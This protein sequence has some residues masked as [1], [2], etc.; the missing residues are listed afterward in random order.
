[1]APKTKSKS[2]AA[3]AAEGK[4]T[5]SIR[6]A[7]NDPPN[8]DMIAKF[9]AEKELQLRRVEE[10]KKQEIMGVSGRA[11]A[12]AGNKDPKK[13]SN[14]LP[15]RHRGRELERDV[16]HLDEDA[17]NDDFSL[18]LEKEEARLAELEA[19]ANQHEAYTND[20]LQEN[21]KLRKH[22]TGGSG[23]SSHFNNM[24]TL[25]DTSAVS[26][27]EADFMARQI[28]QGKEY[29]A[30]DDIIGMSG[31]V[32]MGFGN[33]VLEA[34]DSIMSPYSKN[35]SKGGGGRAGH[36]V[37]HA[38]TERINVLEK[39]VEQLTS[40]LK[41][42]EEE[43]TKLDERYKRTAHDL[44][45]ARK[46]L[47]KQLQQ[48]HEE[49]QKELLTLRQQHAQE[50]S[51]IATSGQNEYAVGSS[52]VNAGK[53]ASPSRQHVRGSHSTQPSSNDVAF[54][55]NKSLMNQLEQLQLEHR[56]LRSQYSEE[57]RTT[58]VETNT[59]FIAQERHLKA[60]IISLKAK[61][62]EL[63]DIIA[64]K[65][66]EV[67]VS[68]SKL[69]S[70][71]NLNKTLES[72]KS[73][74][75]EQQHKLRAD[76][77]NMQQSVQQSFRLESSQGLT[78]GMDSETTIRLH[79]AKFEAKNR[80]LM[81][82]L[83]FLKA[84]LDTEQTANE[85]LKRAS[86]GLKN[87]YEDLRVEFNLRMHEAE[88]SKRQAI[89]D[90]EAK[91]EAMYVE[92][93]ME[94]TTLQSKILFVQNQ[95]N[96]VYQ[97]GSIAKQREETFRTST[98]KAQAQLA[99]SKAEVETLI[100]QVNELR[101]EKEKIL[102]K[103][104]EKPNHEA[105]LR[106]LDNERQYLKS[107][108]SSEIT[109]KAEVTKALT[110][111]QQQLAE[112]TRQWHAD[113]ETLKE[114]LANDQREAVS[115]EQ[116]LKLNIIRLE[117]EENRM[118]GQ[119]KDLKE[120]FT[121]MRDQL[122][123]EQLTIEQLHT[124]Q[125]QLKEDIE[126]A[127]HEI[128]RLKLA[129][130]NT[131]NTHQQTIASLNATISEQDT[132]RIREI[133]KLREELS[134]QYNE[135]SKNQIDALDMRAYFDKER[136]VITRNACCAQLLKGLKQWK[137]CR[138]SQFFRMW[139]TNSTLV[140]VAG[141]FRE[142]VNTLIADTINKCKDDKN[143]ALRAQ[144]TSL[145][146]DLETQR[147]RLDQQYKLREVQLEQAAEQQK[148]L[149]LDEAAQRHTKELEDREDTYYEEYQ[150]LKLEHHEAL[151]RTIA[152]GLT[153]MDKQSQRSIMEVDSILAKEA[154]KQE[155]LRETLTA[156]HEQVC[157]ERLKELRNDLNTQK[158]VE[159]NRLKQEFTDK[160]LSLQRQAQ[161]QLAA[162]SREC[163]Q[164]RIQAI[165]DC[166]AVHAEALVKL[167]NDFEKTKQL[168]QDRFLREAEKKVNATRQQ[169]HVEN[170][171]RIRALRESWAEELEHAMH[172]K[173][174]AL[175][176]LV[177]KKMNEHSVAQEAERV[178]GL[179]LEA[180]KWKQALRDAENRFTLD[181]EKAK[182]LGKT[183]ITE[184][185]AQERTHLENSHK[186]ALVKQEEK[187]TSRVRE[188]TQD[189]QDQMIALRNSLE[190]DKENALQRQKQSIST[191]LS[192][193]FELRLA[194]AVQQAITDTT[195]TYK[196]KLENEQLRLESFKRDVQLQQTRVAEDKNA[197]Q[198]RLDQSEALMKNMENSKLLEIEQVNN[199]CQQDLKELEKKWKI[200]KKE[201]LESLSKQQSDMTV[202]LEAKMKEESDERIHALTVNMKDELEETMRHVNQENLKL[203]SSLEVAMTD[204]RKEKGNLASKLEETTIKLEN[205][206][207]SLYDLQQEIKK[208]EKQHSLMMWKLLARVETMKL[209]FKKGMEEFQVAAANDTLRAKAETQKRC[210]QLS[211][212]MLRISGLISEVEQMRR[213]VNGVLTTYKTDIL[214][215]KRTQI[216]L[217][218]KELER[219]CNE[220]DA[221]EQERDCLEEE[222]EALEGQV[223]STEE[224]IREHNRSSSMQN[225]RI[226]VAH[227]R[228]KKRLDSELER[229][230]DSIEQKRVQ[231][232]E[233]D[234]ASAEK[235]RIRDMKELQMVEWERELVSVLVEQQ[236]TV[237]QLTEESKVFEE[238]GNAIATGIKLPWPAPL[239][240]TMN[241]VAKI[242]AWLASE[243][244]ADAR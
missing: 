243:Q 66:E 38:L 214:G 218:E 236:R 63:E 159:L 145:Q 102:E 172:A 71:V 60:E 2:K 133:A 206:E 97:E 12:N 52:S 103:D 84:Q 192:T 59:K 188:M 153:E 225:G 244:S 190:V 90:T 231:M 17:D 80:Q 127:N 208:R 175:E 230:L 29:F 123:M 147:Q 232:G 134:K 19:M 21:R 179:K 235:S 200:E 199:Q 78:T 141:Q 31:S 242:N 62:T 229:L 13:K 49:H 5:K 177:A 167:K 74:A 33:D 100:A 61:V 116:R 143:R 70:I 16:S 228:K 111:C 237:L 98:Q 89:A 158:L 91:C 204:L 241:D 34:G 168:M 178:R 211:L 189:H 239:N 174:A 194:Q 215:E 25:N 32:V 234:E 181:I 27:S 83:D 3:S 210:D 131:L 68:K 92:R 160:E 105:V 219:I 128:N 10:L 110:Q 125:R 130:V 191:E 9:A 93:M 113:V 121:K 58:A 82:K 132:R 119:N 4:A 166:E 171:D 164:Q 47:N 122:R 118:K 124:S 176:E 51:F 161:D 221:F 45:A 22:L 180:S 170:E 108:L 107:Q 220:R 233:L 42:K 140:G 183:E 202:A 157:K 72:A 23:M 77:K 135:V 50:M 79:D 57:K 217:A 18:L 95:L 184:Q 120:A 117:G 195:A 162:R 109:H 48:T 36:P 146:G 216:K 151:E 64:I 40:T 152:Q 76:L 73:E 209:N 224:L 53:A 56:N 86:D 30:D 85:E 129:E 24:N 182:A 222:I 43:L 150:K 101:A 20:F 142:Q 8:V 186:M 165:E 240:P 227:A 201:A 39:N 213:K 41:R 88:A 238:R 138:L 28:S 55:T 163:E 54:E 46:N 65:D 212:G 197:L 81:N 6:R 69:D 37:S 205:T 139:S 115:V 137:R 156:H 35:P 154:K 15:N 75:I 67:S 94:L 144:E 99:A 1:V 207:D 11:G 149:A 96:E 185:F 136:A 87:K 148:L 187:F 169:M 7:M 223:R 155:E 44:D 26:M 226:N 193:Q 112:V 14:K 198:Y 106:R 104:A 196:S 126:Q 114:T 173:D 203:I